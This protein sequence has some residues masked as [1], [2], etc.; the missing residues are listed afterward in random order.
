M[1]VFGA[2]KG[3]LSYEEMQRIHE[4]VCNILSEMGMRIESHEFLRIMKKYGYEV[5]FSKEIVR[6]PESYIEEM[7]EYNSKNATPVNEK[8][9]RFN[10]GG[11]P[12][13]YLDPKTDDV[14]PHTFESS[15]KMAQVADNL[16][17]I[18][19]LNCIGLPSD[20]PLHAQTFYMKLLS[21]ISS[22]KPYYWGEVPNV[23]YLKY[24]VELCE[25]YCRF[26]GREIEEVA[27]I[28]VHKS[29]PFFLD[30]IKAEVILKARELGLPVGSS[31]GIPS[32]GGTAPVTLA[33]A[34]VT[35]IA[36][37]FSDTLINRALSNEDLKPSFS[38]SLG[39][40]DMRT[41][42]NCACHPESLLV[43]LAMADMA[44]FYGGKVTGMLSGKS[45]AKTIASVQSGFERGTSIL[46]GVMAGVEIYGSLG[47]IS[48]PDGMNSA[49]Q[50]VIDNEIAAIA[51]RFARGFTVDEETLAVDVIKELGHKAFFLGHKH[52]VK[53]FRK[54]L[55]IPKIF[56][57]GISYETWK[58]M[59]GKTEI[60]N[61]REI[62]LD[63]W[64]SSNTKL[65]DNSCIEALMHVIKKAERD[66]KPS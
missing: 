15:F 24:Y 23:K 46:I 14:R 56:I 64:E 1:N 58:N 43:T 25:E 6:F 20:V 47:L 59:G 26:T 12:H 31:S 40:L 41:G 42:L 22:K 34:L 13:L 8:E 44:R 7:V 3:F 29:Y 57:G 61:A 62:A 55:W 11:Y 63:L 5:D 66:L 52:T 50:L 60:D 32:I 2:A 48:E 53:H 38:V 54:E 10:A 39:V 35:E 9:L 27:N 37:R 33:G 65:L 19:S 28:I 18:S 45:Q 36:D 21:W 51:K 17:N 49:V 16:E 4:S 30:K